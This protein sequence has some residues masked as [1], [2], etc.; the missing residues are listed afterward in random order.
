MALA[1][2]DVRAI[3]SGGGD[4]DPDLPWPRIRSRT[5]LDTKHLRTTEIG[6]SENYHRE[7]P[8]S[9]VMDACH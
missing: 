7:T 1:L 3:H 9:A 2:K 4:A 5:L 8:E 6:K